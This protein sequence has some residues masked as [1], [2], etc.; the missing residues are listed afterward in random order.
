MRAKP[1]IKKEE[2]EK[3]T[4]YGRGITSVAY[5]MPDGAVRDFAVMV[6]RSSVGVVAL[7]E[8]G[9]VLLAQQFRPGPEKVLDEIVG[10]AIDAGES[11]EDA[12]RRELREETGYEGEI[13]YVGHM[14]TDAYGTHVR[15]YCVALDCKQIGEQSLD[16][17]EFVEVEEMTVDAF[18][19]HVRSG[20][21]TDVGGAYACL[22]YLVREGVIPSP[23]ADK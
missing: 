10:G 18:W 20:D 15:H 11:P 21:L 3:Y 7:T 6:G 22:D 23:Y 4:A 13:R 17:G 5:E 14:H 12:G 1:W 9:N 2:E 16:E 8:E 19:A